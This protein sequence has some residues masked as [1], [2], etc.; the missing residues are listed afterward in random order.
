[1]TMLRRVRWLTALFI[2]GLVLSG[3]TAIPL[4]TELNWLTGWLGASGSSGSS[5][6]RWVERVRAALAET[7][8]RY[9]FLTYGTD[10][11]AFG[12]F[13]IA[14]AFCWAWRDPVRCRWMYDYGLVACALV[15]PYALVMGGLRGIPPGWRLIDCSFGVCGAIPLW[16]CRRYLRRL[17]PRSVP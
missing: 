13:M 10:W 17:H 8:S 16:L 12:H 1:M 3:A 15:I 14:L 2:L 6:L 9:P 5:L 7:N 4:E 11:L